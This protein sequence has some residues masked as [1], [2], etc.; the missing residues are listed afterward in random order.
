MDRVTAMQ[1]MARDNTKYLYALDRFTQPLYRMNPTKLS[2]YLP[3]L[4]YAIRMIH[5]TSRFF[6]TRRTVTAIFVKV[7]KLISGKIFI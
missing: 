2:K 7:N 1:I 5:S 4:M 3:S 6:N